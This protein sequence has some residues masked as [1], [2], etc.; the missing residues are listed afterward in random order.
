MTVYTYNKQ[1]INGVNERVIICIFRHRA[2]L[3]EYGIM[4]K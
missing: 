4:L 2:S 1:L 3:E